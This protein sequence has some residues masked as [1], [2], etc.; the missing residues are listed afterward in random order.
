MFD[1]LASTKSAYMIQ[2]KANPYVKPPA[3]PAELWDMFRLRDEIMKDGM[4]QAAQ[5]QV[6]TEEE[7]T[8]VSRMRGIVSSAVNAGVTSGVDQA[9]EEIKERME[10]EK[11]LAQ[12]RGDGKG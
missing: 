11:K 2:F 7:D 12:S 8:L 5:A 10:K 6:M 3:M 4:V 9:L 1:Y